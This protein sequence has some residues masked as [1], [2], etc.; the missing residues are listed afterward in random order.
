[1][2]VAMQ[3]GQLH[4][5]LTLIEE[6]IS[7][8]DAE[9]F[10]QKLVEQAMGI[11]LLEI[12]PLVDLSLD[13]RAVSLIVEQHLVPMRQNM[14]G[15]IKFRNIIAGKISEEVLGGE[16]WFGEPGSSTVCRRR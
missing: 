2:H 3:A 9:E 13:G 16:V 12:N 14:V 7:T 1:M 15:F 6:L 5:S 10:G 8:V 4:K 11:H